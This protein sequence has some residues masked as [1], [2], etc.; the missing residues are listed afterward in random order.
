MNEIG[1]IKLKDG[2][3]QKLPTK[4]STFGSGETLFLQMTESSRNEGIIF[5]KKT[6][7]FRF[8]ILKI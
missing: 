8:V 5:Q 1:V 7:K 3:Y 6:E 4:S 2:I